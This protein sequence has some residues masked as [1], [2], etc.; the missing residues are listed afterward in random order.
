MCVREC[1]CEG[2]GKKCWCEM[3]DERGLASVCKRVG[4][5]GCEGVRWLVCE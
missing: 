3:V 2:K 4:Q 1:G 5:C